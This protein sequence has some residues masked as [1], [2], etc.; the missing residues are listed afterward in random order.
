MSKPLISVIMPV[1]NTEKYIH[2]A[3]DSILAQTF[4]DF[5]LLL[6]NDGSTDASGAI[7][8]EYA[9][10]DSR[11]RVFHKANGGIS[12]ARNHGLDH[13]RGEWIT[14]VDSDDYALPEL[15]AN[16]GIEDCASDLV[17]QSM[18]V[19]DS[20]DQQFGQGCN[21]S[22]S[23]ESELTPLEAALQL[24]DSNI[25]GFTH[26][27]AYRKST[28]GNDRFDTKIH[29]REDQ[30]FLMR[31]IGRMSSVRFTNK[32]GYVYFSPDWNKKYALKLE[33]SLRYYSSC[34][35]SMN[36]LSIPLTHSL[37]KDIREG[38]CIT[39]NLL[40]KESG[41]RERI[42]I[43]RQLKQILQ[44]DG[45]HSQ[46]FGFTKYLLRHTPLFCGYLAM[47]LHHAIKG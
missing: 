10:N 17:C 28:I 20:R 39:L 37:R 26:T 19:L 41:G 31:I 27:K 40:W 47:M 13:A 14:I 43:V 12:S 2:R 23:K 35:K 21:T 44:T 30:E 25:F 24:A 32:C 8:E 7:C 3:V 33:S 15:L 4:G 34:Y 45:K 11:V 42:K 18:H 16:Y 22:Y 1:Y 46:M 5:E 6:V 36:L 29:L 9:A 38:Y